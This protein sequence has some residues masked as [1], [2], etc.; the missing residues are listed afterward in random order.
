MCILDIYIYMYA[1]IELIQQ[2]E[3]RKS[4]VDW[5]SCDIPRVIER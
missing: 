4:D 1:C 5:Y 3:R 2:W